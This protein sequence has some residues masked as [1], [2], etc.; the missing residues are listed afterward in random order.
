MMKIFIS[1]FIIVY[2]LL[3]SYNQLYAQNPLQKQKGFLSINEIGILVTNESALYN[4]TNSQAISF[5]SFNGYQFGSPFSLGLGL[6]ID[7]Y[8]DR[9]LLPLTIGITGD[10]LKKNITPF[11]RFSI[12]HGFALGK[13]ENDQQVQK[14]GG[15]VFNP[16]LGLKIYVAEGKAFI[17][18]I[19]Y[20]YQETA[21]KQN[22]TTSF[23]TQEA[24]F[25]RIGIAIGFSF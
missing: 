23:L 6:G 20:K 24:T 22:F 9:V 13:Q 19:S 17:L 8:P 3:N 14:V 11:Y 25:R 4:N 7:S 12:G 21:I 16:A 1:F 15:F 5:H 10:F 2:L 18:Q